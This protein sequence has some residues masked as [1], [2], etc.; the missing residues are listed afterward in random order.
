MCKAPELRIS[1]VDTL[2][3]RITID[4]YHS[5]PVIRGLRYRE[6]EE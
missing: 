6:E 3:S 1:T 5:Q 4:L 2:L